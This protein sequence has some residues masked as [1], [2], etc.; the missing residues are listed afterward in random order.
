MHDELQGLDGLLYGIETW[1]K[2][3]H[4]AKLVA[5]LLSRG[6]SVY[7][8]SDHGNTSAIAEGRFQKPGVLAEPASRRA[9]IYQ[10]YTDAIELEKFTTERY[11]GTYLPEGYTAYLFNAGTSY[12]GSWQRIHYAWRH[13]IGRSTG[14]VHSDWR[15]SWLKE[16]VYPK[17]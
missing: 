6:F 8:T 4:L 7:I 13:D 17:T 2:N 9:V 3:G 14:A 12:R 11:S 10:S 15:V 16:S 1:T 5:D